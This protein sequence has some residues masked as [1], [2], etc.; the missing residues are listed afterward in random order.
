[1][2]S[3]I[4]LRMDQLPM[5]IRMFESPH[6]NRA[7]AGVGS[8]GNC[9]TNLGFARNCPGK[10]LAS[11]WANRGK[12]LSN[13]QLAKLYLGIVTQASRKADKQTSRQA[14]KQTSRQADKRTSRQADKQTS[15][16]ADKQT[17]GQ[18][19]KQTSRQVD[20]QTSGQADKRTSRQADKQ[21]SRQADK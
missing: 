15:G 18:A 8:S 13:I 9:P 14:D 17:S 6:H 5:V 12:N 16:Q 1:M 2:P 11:I 21:T 10:F 3:A 4:G 7:K 20:K 19:D